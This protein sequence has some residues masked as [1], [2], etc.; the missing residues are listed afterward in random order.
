MATT[1][2][3]RAQDPLWFKDAVIYETHVKSFYDSNDDG[4][5][6]LRG[7]VQKLD[8]L[9]DLGITCL[10]LLPLFPS[11]LKDD[12][13]DIAD[14]KGIHPDYGTLED[15]KELVAAAHARGIRILVELVVNHTSD[16][17]PWF[18]RA[19]RAPPGSPERAYYV[20]SDTSERYKDARIIF[21]DTEKSNWTWDPEAKQYYW[22]RFFSH[23]PDLNF[24]N[25]AVLQD[26]LDALGFWAELGVDAFRL[27]AVPYLIE[28]DGT[29]C[30]NLPCHPRGDPQDPPLRRRA[31]PRADAARRGEPVARRRPPLL[32]RGRRVPHGVPLPAHAPHLHGAPPR[33]RGAHRRDHAPH[34]RDPR[35]LPVGALPAEPRRAD[36][37]DGDHRRARLHVPRLLAGPADEAQRGD[38]PAPR[39]ARRQLAAAHGALE[40]APLL[41]PRHA[42]RLL[43]RRDRHGRQ[44]LPARPQRRPDA[45]AV[46]AGSERRLLPRATRAGSTR[47]P[48]PTR[49]T[50]T[51]P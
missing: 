36:A 35:H 49:S 1:P 42:D 3:R 25:P 47:R 29:S 12:G 28:Q 20:W 23:Q 18:Q 37:R 8:Y 50:A 9:Q 31:L 34:A 48:S 32:R 19:R 17:H 39:P 40:L 43:R 30:E 41:V 24:E 22:H 45:H 38:P 51:R 46:D 2:R 11:P 26:V 5:G 4:V 27:D 10:W 16:Q 7:L 14:Y 13:Y 44:H 33:G 6:D 15:F 21:T